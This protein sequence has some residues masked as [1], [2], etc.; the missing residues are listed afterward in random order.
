MRSTLQLVLWI[1]WTSHVLSYSEWIPCGELNRALRYPCRC[2]NE[3]PLSS[4]KDSDDGISIDCDKV[5]FMGDFPPLPYGAPIVS[6]SQKWAG[7][8]ALPTEVNSFSFF[9]KFRIQLNAFIQTYFF[10][11]SFLSR[12]CL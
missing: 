5:V 9:R 11:R 2:R 8:Q 3:G 6:F 1:I 7:H 12:V 10:F 4:S